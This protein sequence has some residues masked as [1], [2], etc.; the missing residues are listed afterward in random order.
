MAKQIKITSF[1]GKTKTNEENDDISLVTEVLT[2][3]DESLVG[4][5][6]KLNIN[7]C[8]DEFYYQPKTITTLSHGH[9]GL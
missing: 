1:F 3:E 4:K 7:Y 5:V 6:R 9:R 8:S 2:D